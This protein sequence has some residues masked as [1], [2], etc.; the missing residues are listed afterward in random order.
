MSTMTEKIARER[1]QPARKSFGQLD[2]TGLVSLVGGGTL[3]ATALV[4]SSRARFP[5]AIAGA[6][7]IGNGLLNRRHDQRMAASAKGVRARHGFRFETA[8]TLEASPEQI[9]RVWR[10]LE[11][12]PKVLSHLESVRD[13][14]NGRSH[15]VARGP[16]GPIEWDAEIVTER[17][18]QIVA[19]Q[20]LPGSDLATAG[21]LRLHKAGGDRGTV[22]RLSLKYDP[23]GGQIAA[24]FASLLGQGLENDVR[25]DLRRF[26]QLMEAGEVATTAGQPTGQCVRCEKGGR[27]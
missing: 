10:D 4:T 16:L 6:A 7:L 27:R 2:Q 13:S 15:W 22:L 23:P 1:H 12:L 25:D 9:Y 20:S 11:G 24:R 18:N 5:L 17:E 21:S 3:V 14:G 19:W 8:I 26:K